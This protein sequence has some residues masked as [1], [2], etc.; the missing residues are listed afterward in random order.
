MNW[1][2]ILP[3]S[4]VSLHF[5]TAWGLLSDMT[6]APLWSVLPQTECCSICEH[7]PCFAVRRDSFWRS[8][9]ASPWHGSAW[10]EWPL[11][12]P[13][14]RRLWVKWTACPGRLTTKEGIWSWRTRKGINPRISSLRQLF[15]NSPIQTGFGFRLERTLRIH[16]CLCILN[17]WLVLIEYYDGLTNGMFLSIS[18][19]EPVDPYF[20]WCKF[21]AYSMNNWERDCF[22]LINDSPVSQEKMQQDAAESLR[23]REAEI[24]RVKH[25]SSSQVNPLVFAPA[26]NPASLGAG[27]DQPSKPMG[28]KSV[29]RIPNKPEVPEFDA[30]H[31]GKCCI[32]LSLKAPV[33]ES[34]LLL[35][36]ENGKGMNVDKSKLSPE[37]LKKYEQGFQRNAFNQYVSDKMSLHRTLPD[38]RD[39]EWVPFFCR[40]SIIWSYISV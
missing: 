28:M 26:G 19:L 31:P 36:G 10:W 35:T 12:W 27:D 4:P 17:D 15:W 3:K 6:P 34:H 38:V 25:K 22:N 37:E 29:Y 16:F 33:M 40:W 7:Q 23:L 32:A 1:L 39:K 30:S 24:A 13:V 14:S 11:C 5:S 2:V 20:L 8:S 18:N 21:N 9:L